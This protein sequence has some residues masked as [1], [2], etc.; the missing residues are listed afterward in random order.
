MEHVPAD[1]DELLDIARQLA[2][3]AGELIRSGRACAGEQVAVKSSPTDVVTA[4]DH[5]SERFLVA[6]IARRR[7]GDGVLGE[8]GA[9]REGRTG[10]RWVVDPI[11]GTVN[12]L[13]GIPW[14]AVSVAAELDDIVAV[15]V[16][17]NPENG[18]LYCA[19]RGGGAWLGG[20]RLRCSAE[21]RLGHALVSTGFGYDA[22]RRRE[23]AA[24]AAALLP[25]IRDLRRMGSAA[26]D[27]C[28]VAAG[29]MDGHYE[30]G[31][32][33]WD[34]AAGAL[35][36]AEAGARV[37]GLRGAVAGPECLVAAVP[38]IYPALVGALEQLIPPDP[39]RPLRP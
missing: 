38:G 3:G 4:M 34:Y 31:L 5:A 25:E 17:L 7:P 26:L 22:A 33:A 11:D 2:L 18:E 14:Y 12:Y 36:A 28:Q 23:Q 15:G 35:I 13:Y 37:G 21:D 30:Q 9:S 29:R 1:L 32:S 24:V 19:V 39:P 10:V 6:E 20:R 27:L 16:V 8:E